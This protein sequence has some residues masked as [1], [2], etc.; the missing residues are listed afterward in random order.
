MAASQFFHEAPEGS[1]RSERGR[2]G[3]CS[4]HLPRGEGEAGG[5]EETSRG[6]SS[7]RAQKATLK[8]PIV[9]W[10]YAQEH[11]EV[12]D[13]PTAEGGGRRLK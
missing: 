13:E 10:E 11:D 4:E 5:P 7:R 8:E 12:T 6:W 2:V 1:T 9:A 3:H